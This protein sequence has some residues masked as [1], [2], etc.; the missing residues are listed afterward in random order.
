VPGRSGINDVCAVVA[1][2]VAEL[3]AGF[4]EIAKRTT[5]HRRLQSDEPTAVDDHGGSQKNWLRERRNNCDWRTIRRNGMH[6]PRQ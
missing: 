2:S 1:L 3:P 6:R 5:T 4:A